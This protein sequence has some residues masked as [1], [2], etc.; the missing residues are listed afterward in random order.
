[1]TRESAEAVALHRSISELFLSITS[2]PSLIE[3]IEKEISE[4]IPEKKKTLQAFPEKKNAMI[5]FSYLF[6]SLVN[7]TRPLTILRINQLT[8]VPIRSVDFG[9]FCVQDCYI[10]LNVESDP[11]KYS[12]YTWIAEEAQV[13]KK[14]HLSNICFVL[15]CMLSA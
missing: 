8:P 4:S 1:M 6:D 15:R 11:L 9:K 5:D 14:V 2:S 12:I 13:D 10:V 7:L 3:N